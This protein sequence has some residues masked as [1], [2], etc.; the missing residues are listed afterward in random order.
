MRINSEQ[1]YNISKVKISKLK[2]P[3]LSKEISHCVV[4]PDRIL[5]ESIIFVPKLYFFVQTPKKKMFRINAIMLNN[6]DVYSKAHNVQCSNQSQ[7]NILYVIYLCF[8]VI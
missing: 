8:V 5:S 7:M 2:I 4:G 3:P 6:V 1:F